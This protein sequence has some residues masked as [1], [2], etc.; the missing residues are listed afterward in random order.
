MSL[1]V[2]GVEIENVVANSINIDKVVENGV[3]VTL[4]SI[5]A[6]Y[7]TTSKIKK[8]KF[9][10]VWFEADLEYYGAFNPEAY[11]NIWRIKANNIT[12][13]SSW[14]NAPLTASGTVTLK[15]NKI[16]EQTPFKTKLIY[17]GSF[18]DSITIKA[19][20]NIKYSNYS[21]EVRIKNIIFKIKE[22]K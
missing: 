9:Y 14:N 19:G 21:V 17:K 15:K 1:V 7:N 13:V 5:G 16:M 12:D 20:A 11:V 18:K 6:N 10:E 22:I 8:D 2:N 4:I 3:V